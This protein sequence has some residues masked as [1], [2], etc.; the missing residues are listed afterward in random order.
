MIGL[1]VIGMGVGYLV[2]ALTWI[3]GA[4]IAMA[5]LALMASGAGTVILLALLQS[6]QAPPARTTTAELA[7]S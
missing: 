3:S 7:R 2:A 6:F 4:G 1:I 5:G